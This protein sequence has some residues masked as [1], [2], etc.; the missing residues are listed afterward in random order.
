MPP[1]YRQAGESTVLSG[2][3]AAVAQRASIWRAARAGIARIRVLDRRPALMLHVHCPLRSAAVSASDAARRLRSRASS[4]IGDTRRCHSVT[5]ARRLGATRSGRRVPAS[6]VLDHAIARN[7]F[8]RRSCGAA[9][10]PEQRVERRR[11]GRDH[12]FSAL[13]ASAAP[14][15]ALSSSDTRPLILLPIVRLQTIDTRGSHGP[16]HTLRAA[17]SGSGWRSFAS[18]SRKR[19]SDGSAI[20]GP[21]PFTQLFRPS[22]LCDRVESAR[23]PQAHKSLDSNKAR[24]CSPMQRDLQ[25]PEADGAR[26]PFAVLDRPLVHDGRGPSIPAVGKSHWRRTLQPAASGCPSELRSV[27]AKAG[28]RC[29]VRQ[30]D[31]RVGASS[32]SADPRLRLP[33]ASL[34]TTPNLP[35]S[36]GR[37]ACAR[38]TLR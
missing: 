10:G 37:R 27:G 16:H 20:T 29:A 25:G 19:R 5:C 34:S 15:L 38:A 30:T 28:H 35:L 24:Q 9:L 36:P 17:P 13:R 3:R 31:V 21:T 11:V 32:V 6:F 8:P 4:R 14:A 1:A 23:H 2:L 33:A 18:S 7:L 26:T 12:P 22:S